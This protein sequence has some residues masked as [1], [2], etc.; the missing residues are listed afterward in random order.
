M[1][2]L[3]GLY[4]RGGFFFGKSSKKK[5]NEGPS[6]CHESPSRY[7]TVFIVSKRKCATSF[8]PVS[9]TGGQVRTSTAAEA[10]FDLSSLQMSCV[11]ITHT[12]RLTCTTRNKTSHHVLRRAAAWKSELSGRFTAERLLQ[13][14]PPASS[15]KTA[16]SL[17]TALIFPDCWLVS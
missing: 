11:V 4:S 3:D 7:F 6:V 5:I 8:V 9:R 13:L 14:R 1:S 15:P 10:S 17:F 12:E 16:S 2:G